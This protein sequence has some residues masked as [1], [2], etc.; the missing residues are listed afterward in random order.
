MTMTP[1][2]QFRATVSQF[3]L[4]CVYM[5]D[6]FLKSECSFL[7]LLDEH[8]IPVVWQDDFHGGYVCPEFERKPR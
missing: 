1:I 5:G 4:H 6:T 8:G 2:Q 3:C 7:D